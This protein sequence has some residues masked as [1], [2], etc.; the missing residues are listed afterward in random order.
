MLSNATMSRLSNLVKCNNVEVVECCQMQQCRRCQSL[1]NATMSKMSIFVKCKVITKSSNHPFLPHFLIFFNKGQE[2]HNPQSAASTPSYTATNN[3]HTKKK[4]PDYPIYWNSRAPLFRSA[5]R[6]L[7]LRRCYR[8]RLR[9][10]HC[11]ASRQD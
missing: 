2:T 3:H 8:R 9:C 11:L 7:H 6:R 4:E 10:H 5:N 1:S